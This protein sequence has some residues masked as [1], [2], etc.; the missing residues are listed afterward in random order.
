M[1]HVGTTKLATHYI[2]KQWTKYV[3][4]N[5]KRDI[6]ERSMDS[7]ESIELQTLRFANIKS[8]LMELGKTV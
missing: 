2:M 8:A 4:A 3:N 6:G 7:G 5:V 1:H